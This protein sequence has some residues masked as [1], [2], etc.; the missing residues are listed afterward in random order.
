[1]QELWRHHNT[2]LELGRNTGL[3][4][5]E[6]IQIWLE[7]GESILTLTCQELGDGILTLTWQELGDGILTLTWQE[8]GDGILTLQELGESILTG[9]E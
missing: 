1:M 4:L 3:K 9:L 8:L 2:W 7:L 6:C 5:R